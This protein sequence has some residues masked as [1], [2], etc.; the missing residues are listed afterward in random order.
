MV[1][2]TAGS[3]DPASAQAPLPESAPRPPEVRKDPAPDWVIDE[4]VDPASRPANEAEVGDTYFLRAENQFDVG[5]RTNYYRYLKR[6]ENES[7]LQDGA[8]LTFGFDPHYQTFSFH[9][10]VIHRDGKTLDRLAGQEFKVIQREEDHERQL[11]DDSLSVIAVLEDIRVGDVIEY[12]FSIRGDNPVFEG[13]AY[14]SLTTSYSQPVG[15]ILGVLRHPES[16]PMQ[17]TRHS[18]ELEPEISTDA[19]NRVLQW[20]IEKPAALLSEGG[21]PSHYDPWGW[22]E[23][24]SWKDWGEVAEWAEKRYPIPETLP[25]EL[26]EIAERLSGLAGEE[27]KILGALRFAQDEIRYLGMFDGVHSH[28]P[29]PIE[30]I[31]KRRFG[32]CKDKTLLLVTLL[33]HL[34]FEA[35]P[36]LVHTSSGKAIKTWAP[37]PFAFNHLVTVVRLGGDRIWLDPTNSYQRGSLRSLYFPDYGHA[38]VLGP[39]PDDAARLEEVTPQGF[40]LS[41]TRVKEVFRLPE[42]RG[43]VT[44]EVETTYRG[45]DA[46]SI[47]AY[48]AANAPAEIQRRYVNYYSATYEGIEAE[49]NFEVEDDEQANVVTVLESYRIP[50]IWEENPDNPGRFEASFPSKYI[51]DRLWTPSTKKRTMPF[52]IDHPVDASHHIEIHLPDPMNEKAKLVEIEDPAFRYTYRERFEGP[53][54]KVDHTYRSLGDAVAPERIGNYLVQVGKAENHTDYSIWISRAMH[55]GTSAPETYRFNWILAAVTLLTLAGATLAALIVPHLRHRLKPKP[56]YEARL[57]GIS[58]WL[59]LVAIGVWIRPVAGL[60]GLIFGLYNHD[61]DTWKSLTDESG[62]AYHELWAPFLLLE[63]FCDTVWIPFSILALVL[64]HKKHLLFPPVMACLFVFELATSALF[65][66]GATHITGAGSEV[67]KEYLSYLRPSI[68]GVVIWLPYLLV[69]RRV[70][71]TF[72]RGGTD[73]DPPPLPPRLTNPPSGDNSPPGAASPAP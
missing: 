37:T 18:T 41:Q 56:G 47:R 16:Y 34:G 4:P 22:V 32:D 26:Q 12:A 58:G 28:Q 69:S 50:E 64:F 19:S 29:Y 11:Y 46:D 70:A 68:S 15:A 49:K 36:A 10:L 13:R 44:L 60:I 65:F 73:A 57:D 25:A 31:A 43:P 21:L 59:G 55:E 67:S 5:T 23:A 17:L 14:W 38:L 8:Q 1:F 35:S 20:F 27:E 39:G 30:V 51:Y 33:R 24:T 42:Y 48:F 40:D 3:H 2:L 9:R 52:A 71:S 45:S 7:A 6:L 53:V 62:S 54:T 66:G 63:A 61:L 72:R